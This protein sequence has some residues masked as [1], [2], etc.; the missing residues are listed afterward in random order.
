MSD[1]G[2][3]GVDELADVPGLFVRGGF[4]IAL[5]FAEIGHFAEESPGDFF[6]VREV[7][8][9]V[10]EAASSLDLESKDKL[11]KSDLALLAV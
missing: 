3:Q 7:E 1:N 8:L 5:A 6:L 4:A 9:V 2:H 10:T 11:D